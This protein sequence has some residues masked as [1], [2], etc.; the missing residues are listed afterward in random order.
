M[1][2][3]KELNALI[4]LGPG[5]GRG[6]SRRSRRAWRGAA[7]H[8]LLRTEPPASG[9]AS[10]SEDED[11]DDDE[12]DEE[13]DERGGGGGG[14]ARAR[15]ARGDY[16]R[17]CKVCYP[18]C[19]FVILAA[20]VVACV[21][22]VW[23]QVALKEDLDGLKDQFRILESNQKS[24]FQE[25]PK[26]NEDLLRKQKQLEKIESGDLGLSKVWINI[27][28]M[29]KQI[30]LLTS[31]V[32]R[33]KANIK[34]ASDLISLPATVEG[35]QKSVASIGSTLNSVRLAVEA[36]QKTVDEHKR[37][38]EALQRDTIQ[39]PEKQSS[40]AAPSPSMVPGLGRK[41]P[42]ENFQQD[43]LHLQ[44]SLEEVNR[45][46]LGY[47]RKNDLKL[48]GMDGTVRN[49]TQRVNSIGSSLVV[50]S[51]L[52]KRENLSFTTV[53]AG[54]ASLNRDSHRTVGE[55]APILKK[56]DNEDT[57]ASKLKEKLQLIN[58]LTGKP[59]PKQPREEASE[60]EKKQSSASK[61][62]TFPKYSPRS[63]GN[64]METAAHLR[65]VSIPEIS[66]LTADLQDL[67]QKTDQGPEGKL[68]YQDLQD[69]LG[70][71]VPSAQSMAEFDMD[72]DGRYSFLE[73]TL[74]LGIEHM[75]QN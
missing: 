24:S 37:T 11:D 67:F 57:Q 15:F 47:Q 41:S 44:S 74:A 23:M 2:K 72:G 65:P 12:D 4:G 28:E 53:A 34:S 60:D 3:R 64:Q 6:R 40:K 70:S 59:E 14:G 32:N 39:H 31:T 21:G 8:R 25:I 71:G 58:A 38:I 42:R 35:L 36:V 51:K 45:T 46:L 56:E 73:L 33:L 17:C 29:T 50:L 52:G 75:G 22:L 18:L 10:S 62:S 1:K 43:M 54:A 30:A 63:L 19:A 16:F 13:E 9:S 48:L 66:S 5:D 68:S 7:G 55:Q 20:C 69:L 27:T 49:L 61:P 26:L